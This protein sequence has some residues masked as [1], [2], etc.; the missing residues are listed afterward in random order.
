MGVLPHMWEK[1]PPFGAKRP[2]PVYKPV[3]VM[4]FKLNYDLWQLKFYC[5]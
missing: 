2:P 1:R 4:N 3:T 5:N